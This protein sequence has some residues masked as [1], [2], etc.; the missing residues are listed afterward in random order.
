MGCFMQQKDGKIAAVVLYYTAIYR[1]QYF[2]V[3]DVWYECGIWIIK[4]A[5]IAGHI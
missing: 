5:I 4:R 1:E 2:I 3:Q